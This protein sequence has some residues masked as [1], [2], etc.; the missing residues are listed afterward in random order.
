[1]L[2]SGEVLKPNGLPYANTEDDWIWMS[3]DCAKAAR[4]KRPC[5]EPW[6]AIFSMPLG[7]RQAESIELQTRS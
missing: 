6:L 5:A 4:W 7:R 2:V 1:M 3:E